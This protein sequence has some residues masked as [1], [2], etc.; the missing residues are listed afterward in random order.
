MYILG[1]NLSHHASICLL[2]DGKLVFY[3][4]D[5]RLTGLK[6][7]DFTRKNLLKC[8]INIS[9]YTKYVDHVIFASYGKNYRHSVP[10]QD[11]ES[12]QIMIEYIKNRFNDYGFEY[13]EIHFHQEHHL[14]HASNAF[15]S[16]TFNEAAALI[17]DGG[18][19][20]YNDYTELREVESM[21]YFSS[22]EYE[23]IKK[24]YSPRDINFKD[25]PEKHNEKCIFSSTLSCGFM[26]NI[27]CHITGTGKAGKLMGLSS[28]G[29]SKNIDTK[30]WFLYDKECDIWYT[31]NQEIL[32]CYRKYSGIKD[33]NPQINHGIIQFEVKTAMNLAKK[34]QEETKDHT[35]RL[36]D[37]LLAKCNTKNIVLSGG[38]FLNCVNNY[39]YLKEFPDLKF[40][41]DP[42]AHDGGTSIGAAKYLWHCTLKNQNRF[43]LETLYLG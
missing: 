6:E 35:V 9:Y 7:K 20:W 23:T 30:D 2:K 19:V 13:G 5:D 18:G 34:A 12:D 32:N 41:I 40:Y 22:T 38:Y 36:I 17:L 29:Y 21:Y 37:Q 31:N 4:E 3:L 28:Y 26:F 24:V 33:L 15:Y 1:I 42:I 11:S 27:L 39:E 14:Y 43:P 25:K 8:L 10:S 16:S